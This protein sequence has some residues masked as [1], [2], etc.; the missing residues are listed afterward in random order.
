MSS[1]F[2]I[3]TARKRSLGQGNIFGSTYQEFCLGGS[4]PQCMLRYP[5][6]EQ[7]PP[8]PGTPQDQAPPGNRHPP[9]RPGTPS[10]HSACWEI[11]ST[12]GRYTS[13]WNAILFVIKSE[14]IDKLFFTQKK[15]YC[16]KSD[17]VVPFR[18]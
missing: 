13:Y 12:S 2:F 9:P 15:E 7:T 10:L 3:F 4:L 16:A 11:R 14:F 5:P 18:Q 17:N 1:C 8:R 6:Q